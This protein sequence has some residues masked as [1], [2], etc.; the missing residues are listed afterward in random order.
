MECES[1]H[2]KRY[3]RNYGKWFLGDVQRAIETYGLIEGGDKICVALS[4]GRDSSVLLYILWY[5]TEYTHLGFDLWALHVR[6]GDYDSTVLGDFC[7]K[8]G[9]FSPRVEYDDNDMIIIRPMVYLDEHRIA[10]IH[11]HSGLPVLAYTC[12]HEAESLRNRYRDAL[13]ELND[14][15]FTKR[16]SLRLVQALENIDHENVWEDLMVG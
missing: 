1:G 3:D 13:S 4:G 2:K 12:P 7:S 5:L 16:F 6:T 11:R 9:S 15:F 14:V 10:G 8:L